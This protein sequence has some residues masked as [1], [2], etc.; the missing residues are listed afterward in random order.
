MIEFKFVSLKDAGMT[1]KN[2]KMLTLEALH[3]LPPIVKKLESG[4]KQVVEYG[5]KLEGKYG[6]LRLLK[7]VVVALGFERVCFRKVG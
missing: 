1:G 3:T 5:R 6:N 7:F 2:A 4:E